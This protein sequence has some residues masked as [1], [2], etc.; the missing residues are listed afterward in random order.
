MKLKLLAFFLS[1]SCLSTMADDV[2]SQFVI[3][4]KNGTHVCYAL[5]EKPKVLFRGSDL[6]VV[7]K[8]IEVSYPLSDMLRFTV[9]NET[10]TS[11]TDLLSEKVHPKIEGEYLIF[12]NTTVNSNVQ[13]FSINGTLIFQKTIQTKGNYSYPI[14]NLKSGIYLVIINKLSYKILVK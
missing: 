1:L 13:I 8:G 10:I 2:K 6:L 3:W 5:N 14:S 9:E 12:P 7:S 11:I 4:A